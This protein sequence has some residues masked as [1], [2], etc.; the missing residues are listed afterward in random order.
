MED[1]LVHEAR[2]LQARVDELV[3][4]NYEVF[5]H[6]SSSIYDLKSALSNLP[7][8]I[9]NTNDKIESLSA[10]LS[11]SSSKLSDLA[12]THASSRSSI[13]SLPPLLTLLEAPQLIDLLIRTSKYKE[14][15]QVA[16]HVLSLPD[17]SSII[18]KVRRRRARAFG[19]L[20]DHSRSTIH[21]PC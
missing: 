21:A 2:V 12:S 15:V 20:S 11:S 7:N 8:H 3:G 14:A 18:T 9:S 5:L 10:S 4:S 17:S 16:A 6:Q 1:E 13:S 19:E